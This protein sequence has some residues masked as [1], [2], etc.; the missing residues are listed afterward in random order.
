MADIIRDNN[1]LVI[2]A[3]F[4]LTSCVKEDYSNC[5]DYGKYIVTFYE[6]QVQ[7]SLNDCNVLLCAVAQGDTAPYKAYYYKIIA[8]DNDFH[9]EKPLKLFPDYYSFKVLKSIN[10]MSM[11]DNFVKL[12]NGEA[13]MYV[14]CP[15]RV[16]KSPNNKFGLNFGLF[17]SLIR[18]ICY[19]NQSDSSM[20]EIAKVEISSPDDNSI[21]LNI[22][23]GECN[24]A[25]SVTDFY[26][27][28]ALEREPDIYYYFCVPLVKSRYLNFKI[29]IRNIET[30]KKNI[31]YSRAF[32]KTNIEQGNIYDFSFDVTPQG[33]EY[34]ATTITDWTTYI[35]SQDI[36][37]N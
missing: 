10:K 26:D 1:I 16:T 24:Y 20:Y 14:D 4:F 32:L 13:Y 35:C 3:L 15:G 29:S 7:E 25:Q 2:L 37:L 12:K 17:N 18:V 34:K 8:G 9:S 22:E 21:I 23:S 5:P 31:L 19:F 6:Q 28:C 30:N 11:D 33:I 36:H 27:S